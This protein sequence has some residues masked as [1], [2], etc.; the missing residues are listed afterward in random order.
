MAFI[1]DLHFGLCSLANEGFIETVRRVIVELNLF[2]NS[3]HLWQSARGVR[4]IYLLIASESRDSIE[5]GDALAFDLA[6]FLI[7]SKLQSTLS[8]D[9]SHHEDHDATRIML[10]IETYS[11]TFSRSV[12]SNIRLLLRLA[13]FYN[14]L[15]N[16]YHEFAFHCLCGWGDIE[17]VSHF[18]RCLD[19]SYHPRLFGHLNSH[20]QSP[21]YHAACGGHLDIVELLLDKGCQQYYHDENPPLK[22]ALVYLVCKRPFDYKKCLKSK[23][24]QSRFRGQ[25]RTNVGNSKCPDDYLYYLTCSTWQSTASM[26]KLISLLLPSAE[27]LQQLLTNDI[28]SYDIF[29]LVAIQPNL[30]VVHVL[31]EIL[32]DILERVNPSFLAIS[33]H[34]LDEV[35][36]LIPYHC[37]DDETFIL[38]D[39]ILTKL[40]TVSVPHLNAI[41]TAAHKGLWQL[42]KQALEC[43]LEYSRDGMSLSMLNDIVVAGARHGRFD[44]VDFVYKNYLHGKEVSLRCYRPLLQACLYSHLEVSNFIE[45]ESGHKYLLEAAKLNVASVLGA[46]FDYLLFTDPSAVGDFDSIIK[47]CHSADCLAVL[48]QCFMKSSF[49]VEV[50]FED[51]IQEFCFRVLLL[52]SSKGNAQL[53]LKAITSL[54]DVQLQDFSQHPDFGTVLGNCCY[55]GMKDV[56]ECLHFET[57]QLLEPCSYSE[58]LSPWEIAIAM[59]HV[60]KLSHVEKFPRLS[61]ALSSIPRDSQIHYCMLGDHHRDEQHLACIAPLLFHGVIHKLLSPPDDC[62]ESTILS[63]GYLP[64]RE[65]SAKTFLELFDC[66]IKL[67]KVHFVKGCLEHLGRYAGELLDKMFSFVCHAC[68]RK[69]NMEVL[70]LFVEHLYSVDRLQ[71]HLQVPHEQSLLAIAVSVGSVSSAK[72]LVKWL[73][74]D[75]LTHHTHYRYELRNVLE[76]NSLLH[77]AVLSKSTEMVDYV[78][79]LLGE[80]APKFCFDENFHGHTPLSL[81]FSLGLTHIICYSTLITVASV[82]ITDSEKHITLWRNNMPTQCG[83]FRLLMHSNTLAISADSAN[84][85]SSES[86]S[87]SSRVQ[88]CDFRLPCIVQLF[89]DA[90]RNCRDMVVSRLLF[91]IE[92]FELAQKMFLEFDCELLGILNAAGYL[93][94]VSFNFPQKSLLNIITSC[95]RED[96]LLSLLKL[97]CILHAGLFKQTF[98]FGCELNKSAII[99]YL[100]QEKDTHFLFEEKGITEEGLARAVA[101]GSF[102]TASVIMSE[103]G[104]HLEHKYLPPG[105]QLSEV[106]DLIFTCT[107]YYQILNKFYSSVAQDSH[108]RIPL[109]V[110]WLAH[111]WTKKEAE[112]ITRH[113]G[114]GNPL[115]PWSVKLQSQLGPQE[116]TLSIDWESFT[117]CLN[118]LSQEKGRASKYRH[119]PLLMEAIVFGPCVLGQLCQTRSELSFQ[120][121]DIN[122]FS[123]TADLSSLI[124]SSVTWPQ[125][126]SFSTLGEGQGILTLSFVPAKG[127][128]LF[129]SPNSTVFDDEAPDVMHL[130]EAVDTHQ[131]TDQ[132]DDLVHFTLTVLR[133][134]LQQNLCVSIGFSDEIMDVSDVSLF[135]QIYETIAVILSDIVQVLKVIENHDVGVPL[136]CADWNVTNDQ[137]RKV[138]CS[139]RLR[140]PFKESKIQIDLSDKY[141]SYSLQRD[142]LSVSI[143]DDTL[144]VQFM[145]PRESESMVL[146]VCSRLHNQLLNILF[147][148]VVMTQIQTAREDLEKS[149]DTAIMRDMKNNL[150]LSGF[151]GSDFISLIYEDF[152]GQRLK[153][154]DVDPEQSVYICMFRELKKF[155][156]LFSKL[157]Q[158]FSYQPPLQASVRRVFETGFKVVLSEKSS[159]SYSLKGSV[160]CMMV[161]AQQLIEGLPRRVIME[162]LESLLRS[163][164]GQKQL[165]LERN[166]PSPIMSQIDFENSTGLLY[167]VLNKRGKITIQL[168]NNNS[169]VIS[170]SPSVSCVLD[171]SIS[172]PGPDGSKIK[173]SSSHDSSFSAQ[174]KH[175]SVNGTSNGQ[176]VIEWTPMK[177][178]IHYVRILLNGVPVEGSPFKTHVLNTK[179]TCHRRARVNESISFVV[180][181]NLQFNLT[182]TKNRCC[183]SIPPV[184]LHK[185]RSIRE[186]ISASA[187]GDEPLPPLPPSSFGNS[188]PSQ[189]VQE[190]PGDGCIP[191]HHISMCSRYGGASQWFHVPVGDVVVHISPY[192]I[193]Q[194]QSSQSKRKRRLARHNFK[195]THYTMSSG[196]TRIV[197]TCTRVSEYKLFVSCSKCQ[198]VM[199]VI[200]PDQRTSLPSLLQITPHSH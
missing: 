134:E 133:K 170:Y 197:I 39:N 104:I 161:N 80:D 155:L 183:R 123:N 54:S 99:H 76:S 141:V 34:F 16:G 171:V 48:E 13:K 59:G 90:V 187:S 163:A 160:P 82:S 150:Q 152:D 29:S 182:S 110:A 128:F 43:P 106:I 98:V 108:D 125:E 169:E 74:Q 41:T 27:D 55:W 10:A 9:S 165:I 159:T 192:I 77:L 11:H 156:V 14:K 5:L 92:R 185:R 189:T 195:V 198:S 93:G 113:L 62:G 105:V 89:R 164:Q 127:V 137:K 149:V 196:M 63:D 142:P 111:G 138:P 18:L 73:P 38:L 19:S 172:T 87:I 42:V 101:C 118:H 140:L 144:Y 126:P 66:A 178:G 132:L 100:L 21:M 32:T 102:E 177:I 47:C 173:A 131:V 146:D 8:E 50:R 97:D 69:D 174:N 186:L 40:A 109:S 22:G 78:L 103:C 26:K 7:N 121:F 68:E 36:A 52:Q 79:D 154:C 51:R 124:L 96:L 65:K 72:L 147:S 57:S 162:V 119:T 45:P 75:T 15:H 139:S 190:L 176:I 31:L 117:E 33:D 188:S 1:H 35:V 12:S 107:S 167:P 95:G 17:L 181:H 136:F 168:M 3:V 4:L 83:W 94:G 122:S 179:S 64:F 24:S 49:P 6:S 67:G 2:P 129:P 114:G 23:S 88:V 58:P 166:V 60:G 116:M 44:I 20:Q 135:T 37:S 157:L 158:V 84:V 25:L 130:H 53:A 193:L 199:E 184:V 28:H 46:V 86:S 143:A 145:L 151:L 85:Q 148:H 112:S 91:L 120:C 30:D 71:A 56:L 200:W 191:V 153:L 175:L 70:E 194:R 81:A 115:N 61:Q 180:S